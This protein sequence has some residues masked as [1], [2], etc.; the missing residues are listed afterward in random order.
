MME[1]S[2]NGGVS[3]NSIFVTVLIAI[4][5]LL[6]GF[7]QSVNAED[8]GQETATNTYKYKVDVKQKAQ[9]QREVQVSLPNMDRIDP[10]K[11]ADTVKVILN[12]IYKGKVT[13]ETI[14]TKKI[15]EIDSD[16]KTFEVTASDFGKWRATV[17]FMKKGEVVD[18]EI[19]TV[20]IT[21]DTYEIAPLLATVPGLLYSLKLTGGDVGINSDGDKIPVFLT[22]TRT[23]SFDWDKLP[24][25]CFECPYLTKE[26][27]R[28]S[29]NWNKKIKPIDDYVQ[30][31][32]DLDSSSKFNFYIQDFACHWVLPQLLWEDNDIPESNYSLTL[33]TDGTASYAQFKAAYDNT[34]DAFAKHAELVETIS[35]IKAEVKNGRKMQQSDY[36]KLPH[37]RMSQYQYALLD[38]EPNAK[39]WLVRKSA[40]DTLAIQDTAFAQS[41]VGD[42]RVSNNYINNLL[43]NVQNKGKAD[44]FKALYKFDDSAFEATRAKGKKIMMIL[45]TSKAGENNAPIENYVKLTQAYYGVG[46]EYYYKGHPGYIPEL[47]QGR[48]EE[49]KAMD[50]Q[51]LD[52][53]I[54]AELFV[55]FNPDIYMSGYTSSTFQNSGNAETDCGLY[56][57]TKAAAHSDNNAKVYA[58]N[59][60]FFATDLRVTPASDEVNDVIKNKSHHN[61]LV[62]LEDT[63]QYDFGIYD[64]DAKELYFYKNGKIVE[65]RKPPKT[66]SENPVVAPGKVSAKTT[67]YPKKRSL[68]VTWKKVA[69]ATGYKVLWR[70]AGAAKWSTKTTTKLSHSIKNLKAKNIYDVKVAA[71]KSASGKTV[72]G[73]YSTTAYRYMLDVN[74]KAVAGKRLAKVS[75]KKEKGATGYKIYYST[76]KQMK[77]QKIITLKTSK[78]A[79]YTIKKLKKGK[80]YYI[81][82]RPYKVKSGHTYIGSSGNRKVKVK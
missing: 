22:V 46:Y 6:I 14:S 68:S 66:Q 56:N 33:I 20:G 29:G 31:L 71:V 60:D 80:T 16:T 49:L 35:Q 81:A 78:K 5:I 39:W 54:A 75:W 67:V 45:G 15:S 40:G 38:I 82:V 77:N 34:P 3:K 58:E 36:E 13:R 24:E 43:A 48:V 63:S 10:V 27:S 65:T 26:E 62:E 59:C 52:S 7:A 70:K 44:E 76:N 30:S 41:V 17:Q 72:T 28:Q 69:G 79:S 23:K 9:N 57:I 12:I 74:C 18:E 25:N 8:G 11:H 53:S 42:S 19:S 32:Y 51:I 47:N 50:L 1:K 61:Y 2:V 21:A 64:A 4:I 55:F 73:K 37:G